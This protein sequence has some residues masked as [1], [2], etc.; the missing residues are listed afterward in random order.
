M[1]CNKLCKVHG[2][3]YRMTTSRQ[4]KP[5]DQM[6]SRLAKFGRIKSVKRLRRALKRQNAILMPTGTQIAEKPLSHALKPFK[7]QSKSDN[8]IANPRHGDQQHGKIEQNLVQRNRR[9]S[10]GGCVIYKLDLKTRSSATHP[11]CR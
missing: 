7:Q 11:L 4:I 10:I 6:S 5:S 3:K 2:W 8:L 9:K 1:W